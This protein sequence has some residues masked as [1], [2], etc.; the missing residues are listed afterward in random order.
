MQ[1]RTLQAE[2][3]PLERFY[4]NIYEWYYSEIDYNEMINKLRHTRSKIDRY[5]DIPLNM[6][7]MIEYAGMWRSDGFYA[8]QLF[9]F[10]NKQYN[11]EIAKIINFVTKLE[12]PRLILDICAG[13]GRLAKILTS[14]GFNVKAVDNY[15][16][17]FNKRYFKV[18]NMDVSKGIEK[19]EPDFIIGCWMPY[20]TN[21]TPLFRGAKSVKHYMIIGEDEDG[22]CGGEWQPREGW[23][24]IY[25]KTEC[26]LCRTDTIIF[27]GSKPFIVQQVPAI[28]WGGHHSSIYTFS[29]NHGEV[30]ET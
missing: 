29:R 17:P 13:D 26:G 20:N 10:W 11:D 9:Q 28:D 25:H 18:E 23:Y 8:Q 30:Q 16:W 19:Y 15:S 27:D 6:L 7:T 4:D 21:W 1:L 12:K 14:R 22:C 5:V 3:K 24:S 2:L